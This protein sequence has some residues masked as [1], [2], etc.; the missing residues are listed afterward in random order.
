MLD[1]D[2][3]F[4]VPSKNVVHAKGTFLASDRVALLGPSGCGKTSFLKALVGI[5]PRLSGHVRINDKNLDQDLLKSGILGFAFQSS[6]LFAHLSVIENITLPLDALLPFKKLS[7]ELKRERALTLLKRSGLLSLE[8]KWPHELSGG[9]KKRVS[10]LR[11]L[12]YEPLLLILDEPFADL[13]NDNRE[14]FKLWILDM[15]QEK[16]SIL[17]FVSHQEEDLKTLAT[18]VIKWPP[19]GDANNKEK[20]YF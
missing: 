5:Q 9:E 16:R 3:Q 14:L 18:K 12:I 19:F 7:F 17:L 2:F 1:F 10:L 20:L 8:K 4:C 15:V 11:S 13:D 6:P